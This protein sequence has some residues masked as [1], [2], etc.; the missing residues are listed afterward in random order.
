MNEVCYYPIGLRLQGKTRVAIWHDQGTGGLCM[1]EGRIL[2]FAC[3]EDA[4]LY[5]EKEEFILEPHPAPLYD[6][7]KLSRWL[8]GV[9]NEVECEWLLN[10]W[11]LCSDAAGSIGQAFLG[12]QKNQEF[13]DL[14]D[15]LF[16]GCNLPALRENG[17]RYIPAF[18]Q[19]EIY[20]IRVI[21]KNG[22]R[23]LLRGLQKVLE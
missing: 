1:K 11:N 12:D 14:Y 15:K 19:K 13:N 5:A 8:R 7:D 6:L 16:F 4:F 22:L 20:R 21:L 23:L 10:F 9:E 3:E 2:S 17:E 18:S